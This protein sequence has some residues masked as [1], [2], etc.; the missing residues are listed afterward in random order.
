CRRGPQ[1][2]RRSA[3]ARG[4]GEGR[5]AGHMKRLLPALALVM[6]GACR[7]DTLPVNALT[8]CQTTE[9]LPASVQTDILFVIDDSGSMS[10]EQ[11]NL[12]SNLGAFIDALA[13]SAVQN[14]FRIGVTNSSVDD[15]TNPGTYGSGPSKGDPYPAGALVAIGTDLG[16]IVVPGQL[17]Y[18]TTKYAS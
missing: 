2:R 18:D 11:A 9:V 13:S 17:I 5:A 6:L 14:D 15:F 7:C 16:G 8:S 12:A 1:R 3:G 10:E 4:E